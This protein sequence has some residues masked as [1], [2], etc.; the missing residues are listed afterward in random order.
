LD[1]GGVDDGLI[2][3]VLDDHVDEFDL[4]GGGGGGGEEVAEGFGDGGTVQG[5]EGADEAAEGLA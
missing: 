5:D 2:G 1:E 3:E 4:G